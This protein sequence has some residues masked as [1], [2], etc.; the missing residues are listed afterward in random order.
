VSAQHSSNI[1]CLISVVTTYVL[2]YIDDMHGKL[3]VW[4]VG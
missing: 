2:R 1:V 4:L 3:V